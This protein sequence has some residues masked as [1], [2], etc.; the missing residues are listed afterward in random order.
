MSHV[1]YNNHDINHPWLWCLAGYTASAIERQAV[2]E[3]IFPVPWLAFFTTVCAMCLRRIYARVSFIFPCMDVLSSIMRVQG[4]KKI[5]RDHF[6]TRKSTSW[7][8]L[9]SYFEALLE[10]GFTDSKAE[11]E[12]ERPIF[13]LSKSK[14]EF[15]KQIESR[16]S[17]GEGLIPFDSWIR[18]YN[19]IAIPESVSQE[20]GETYKLLRRCV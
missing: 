14:I 2:S 9:K 20:G 7:K 15:Q 17:S 16:L 4:I 18:S 3:T 12:W 13:R 10:S 6:C 8:L 1:E 11:I 5:Y 19:G